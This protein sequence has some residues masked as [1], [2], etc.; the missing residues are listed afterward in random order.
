[1]SSAHYYQRP[2][3]NYINFDSTRTQLSGH[4]GKIKIGKGSKGLWR[5]ST[6]LNWRSPGLDL[7]DI[8]F[9]QTADI[10]KQVNSLSYFINKPASIFRTY[11]I[12]VSESN[13]W[14]FGGSYLASGAGLNLY[15]EFLNKWALN[16]SLNYTSQMLD[17]RILRGGYAMLVPANWSDY[18]YLRTDYS[19]KLFF[20]INANLSASDNKS[21]RFYSLQPGVSLMVTNT[22]KISVSVNYDHNLDKLQY[23]DTK[24]VQDEYVY[25]LGK[26]S[27]QT[28]GSTFRI[29]YNITPELSIQYY[30]NPFTSIGKYSEFKAVTDPEAESYSDRY[31][32]LNPLLNNDNEYEIS[33]NIDATTDYKFG[34]PDFNFSQFRSNLVF[35]W[36]FRPGSQLYLVWSQDKTNFVQ[37]GID[38]IHDALT[39]IRKV[40]PT[41]IFLIKFNYWFSI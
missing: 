12:G 40:Y 7:N 1:M 16:T 32:N 31:I 35:R 5:Y 33:D 21:I 34:N 17:T 38:S 26:I 11:T 2:G 41:N 19:K 23:V 24:K 39:N 29:D 20:D 9:M 28:L 10:I 27:Q 25:I 22:L 14:D 18:F 37:P 3:T 30:G 36:E 13:H 8:G 4:G 15:M 6:E